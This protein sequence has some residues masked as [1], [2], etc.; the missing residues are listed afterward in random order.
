M[1]H[2]AQEAFLAILRCV[3]THAAIV[4]RRIPNAHDREDFIQETLCIAWKWTLRM[5]ERQQKDPRAFPTAVATLAAKHA[6]SGRKFVGGKLGKNDALSR[7][8]KARGGF[9]VRPLPSTAAS[10]EQLYGAVKGQQRHDALEEIL[11]EHDRSPV[12]DQVASRIDFATWRLGH[13]ERRREMLDEMVAGETTTELAEKFDV[14]PARISQ[15]RREFLSAW[16]SY[17]GE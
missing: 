10:H 5:T 3:E 12:P 17:C 6:R 7:F 16:R 1:S 15:M 4:C 9:T 14:S 8:A 11:G 2:K 13:D